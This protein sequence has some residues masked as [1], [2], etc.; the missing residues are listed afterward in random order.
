MG[1]KVV[2]TKSHEFTTE[3]I[4]DLIVTALEGGINYWCGSAKIV[5]FPNG[6]FTGVSN[7]DQTNVR[8]ASDAIGY[9]GKLTLTDAEDKDVSWE[10]DL[11]KMLKGIQMYCEENNIAPEDLM[12]N[13]DADTA[14]GIVQ[15][16][17]FNEIV[18]G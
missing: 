15:Y 5:K 16:V 4:N 8:Y 3:D 9:G 17:L 18:Y 11:P 12:D 14:D 1:H 7:E 6:T 2:V 13:H 10:L